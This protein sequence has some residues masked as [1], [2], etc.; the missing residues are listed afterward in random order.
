MR[1]ISGSAKG[2]KLKFPKIAD[3][4]KVRPLSDFAKEAL[5][6]LLRLRI[7]GARFLDLFAGTG[8]VG[9]EALS[10]GAEICFFVGTDKK[11]V[12]IIRENLEHTLLT[13]KAE[14]FQMDVTRSIEYF[15]R[16][17]AQFD[18]IFIG[19]PYKLPLLEPTVIEI[20]KTGIIND[21]SI[22][23]AEHNRQQELLVEYGTLKKVRS[24][25][26]GDTVFSFYK[27][28]Q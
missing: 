13:G 22:I 27:K 6:D 23:I 5:F 11:T 3:K 7:E 14:V 21:N 10:R 18:L 9:I 2:R 25:K 28:K 26:Y 8:Q 1:V 15:G 20:E 4:K 19:A 16:R 24:E 12:E 17:G